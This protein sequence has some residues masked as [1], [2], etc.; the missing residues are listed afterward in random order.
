VNGF[1]FDTLTFLYKAG[2]SPAYRYDTNA[3]IQ[4]YTRAGCPPTKNVSEFLERFGGLYISTVSK[5]RSALYFEIDPLTST[6]YTGDICSD[7]DYIC[8]AIGIPNV[9][10][11][12]IGS[13]DRRNM[14]LL[15]ATTGQ[16][17]A[18]QDEVLLKVGLTGEDAIEA[19]CT[20]RELKRY[21][22][23]STST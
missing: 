10:F 13:S 22:L 17:Y 9:P 19:L 7:Y 14:E 16:V 21:H 23:N 2:W 15:M 12:E 18:L 3:F 5:P 4:L 1:S 8:E 6:V 11:Y 20:G